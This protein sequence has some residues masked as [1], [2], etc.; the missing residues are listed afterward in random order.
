MAPLNAPA[1]AVV[2]ASEQEIEGDEESDAAEVAAQNLI[3]F[4]GK[5]DRV[6]VTPP[7]AGAFS[8]VGKMQT[9]GE[10]HCTAT[11]IAPDLAITAAH[12]FLMTPRK[13]DKGRWFWAGYH[14]GKWLARYRIENQFF[15]P[16]FR[17]GLEYKG[18]DVYIKPQAA[19]YDIALIKL[20]LVDG[21]P[22]KPMPVFSGNADALLAKIQQ[23]D[24]EVTQAGFASD[25][26]QVLTAHQ[27]CQVTALIEDNTLEHQCDTLSGDSGSPLWLV[28]EKGPMLVAVQSSAPDWFNRDKADN[29]AVTV[30][31][32]PKR[33][34]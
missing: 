10:S 8:A 5:D 18:D 12:C 14:E 21:I 22:P 25:H 9:S 7:Y 2:A 16:K 27:G 19:P 31:Q 33:P 4:F 1:S 13:L 32:M 6:F 20:K 34:K 17:K 3:L 15:H 30:L 23:Y 11:L 28:T 26:N 24:S 29:T